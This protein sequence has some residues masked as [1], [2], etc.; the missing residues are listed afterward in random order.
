GAEVDLTASGPGEAFDRLD[1]LIAATG[2]TLVHPF[3]DPHTIAGQGTVGL[4][5]LEDVGGLDLLVVAVG[6]AGLIS[7]IPPLPKA[8]RPDVRI[9]AV[10]PVASAALKEA[11]AAGGPVRVDPRSVADGLNA[12]FVGE[13]GFAIAS[14]LVDEVVLVEETEIEA[15][16]RFLYERAKL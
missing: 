16:M 4:E 15:A 2:R 13:H 8:R 11:L 6:G 14:A 7:G 9:V 10:E 5:L 1:E 3:D 12:P